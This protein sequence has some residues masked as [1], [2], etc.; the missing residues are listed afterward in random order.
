M[1]TTE[2]PTTQYLT[3][4]IANVPLMLAAET[5]VKVVEASPQV[6]LSFREAGF[7]PS[8]SHSIRWLNLH[9]R[10]SEATPSS[11]R[12]FLIVLRDGDLNLWGL[13]ADSLPNLLAIATE[14]LEPLP[15]AEESIPSAE[16]CQ[17]PHAIASHV[18]FAGS[19]RVFVLDLEKIL[20]LSIP[21]AA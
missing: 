20:A 8:G 6:I 9:E 2:S 13:L 19:G 15:P 4:A 16:A 5:I 14:A 3:F 21:V 17:S 10:L 18:L 11:D 12:Q 1:A 7:V